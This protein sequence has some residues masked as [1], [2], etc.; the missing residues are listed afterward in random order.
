MYDK[1]CSRCGCSWSEF[2]R[3]GLFG[4]PY[5]YDEFAKEL[6]PTLK[7][8]QKQ[9][10]HVGSK[11][12]YSVEDK[13]L[14]ATYKSLVEQKELAGIEQRF[15]DMAKISNQILEVVEKLKERGLI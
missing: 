3:T 1:T 9:L 13:R 7:K 10:Y 11:P 5:C 15:A 4:C 14:L 2:T 6:A 8:I 12:K